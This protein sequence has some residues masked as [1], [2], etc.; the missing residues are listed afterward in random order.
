M[1]RIVR[2]PFEAE[3]VNF[4]SSEYFSGD[5]KELSEHTGY[6][7]QQLECWTSGKRKPHKATLRYLISAVIAPELK[8]V[9]EFFPV[10]INSAGDISKEIN[11]AL[12]VHADKPGIYAFYDSMCNL[13]YI[14]KAAQGLFREVYQQL[15]GPLGIK[16]P[17]ALKKPPNN[18]WRA[19]SFISAYEVPSIDHLDYP[20]HIESLI[21]RISKPI[22][23]K[24]LGNLNG[25]KRPQDDL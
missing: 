2:K 12:G 10:N 9:C 1:K 17:T 6:T 13:I 24:I 22:G 23:N 21:L 25:S 7:K 16:F 5:I 19:T 18:R 15:R 11:K 20:K 4:L 14:G 3:L 8:I